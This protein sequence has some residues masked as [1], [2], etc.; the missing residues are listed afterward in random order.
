LF[1]AVGYRVAGTQGMIIALIV[2]AAMNLFT[3]W[4][5][6][7]IVLS[8]YGALEVGEIEAPGL[9]RIVRDLAGRAG[10]TLSFGRVIRKLGNRRFRRAEAISP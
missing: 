7:R 1:M 10:V 5:A 9:L 8:M 2:A 3:Y 4:S 6:D